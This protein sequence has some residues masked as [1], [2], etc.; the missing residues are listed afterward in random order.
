MRW[1]LCYRFYGVYNINDGLVLVFTVYLSINTNC[2]HHSS[3]WLGLY[4]LLP[5]TVCSYKEEKFNQLP[6]SSKH[7]AGLNCWSVSIMLCF[8]TVLACIIH[9]SVIGIIKM[10]VT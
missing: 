7:S 5:H 4:L 8:K 2:L 6:L 3:K 10:D 9:V 1:L